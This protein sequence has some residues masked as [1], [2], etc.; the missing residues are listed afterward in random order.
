MCKHMKKRVNDN[1]NQNRKI[2]RQIQIKIFDPT[3]WDI[4]PIM[5]TKFIYENKFVIQ[6]NNN[7]NRHMGYL[8][9]FY[10]ILKNE[11][12]QYKT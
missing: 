6:P 2:K 10:F 12:H 8:N 5:L 1:Y 7:E 3:T 4:H 11:A 9:N